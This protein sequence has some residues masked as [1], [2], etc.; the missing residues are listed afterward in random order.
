MNKRHVRLYTCLAISL[1][2]AVLVT[3][4][5]LTTLA[6]SRTNTIKM[7]N[8]SL[9]NNIDIAFWADIDEATAKK[10][11]TYMTFNDGYP[12]VYDCMATSG[13]VSYALYTYD[14][15]LP[16]NMADTVTAKLYVNGE[17]A[18]TREYSVKEYCQSILQ[19]GSSE[20]LKTFVSNLLVYGAKAQLYLGE[21]TD[22]L[23]TNGV[24]GLMASDEPTELTVLSPLERLDDLAEDEQATVTAVG[25]R[26]ANSVSIY[27]DV[28]LPSGA[29]ADDFDV[30]LNINGRQLSATLTKRENGQYRALFD[31]LM[32]SEFFDEVRVA[33]YKKDSR[34]SRHV[35]Y[36]V[37][38]YLKS[39]TDDK[40]FSDE[41]I[42]LAKAIYNYGL[43]AH[44]YTGDHV[45]SM[46]GKV[47]AAGRGSSSKDDHG[48]ITYTCALCDEVIDIIDV[49]HLRTFDAT[50]TNGSPANGSGSQ[51]LFDITT[52]KD[53]NNAYMS[54]LR[55]SHT[56]SGSL[57]YYFTIGQSSILSG[58]YMPSDTYTFSLDVRAPEGGVAATSVNLQNNRFSTDGRWGKLLDINA[59]GSLS[60]N[61]TSIAPAG[62][63]NADAWTSILMTLE[64]CE[65]YGEESIYVE[66]Y[67]NGTYATSCVISNA[68]GNG[69]FTN[70]HI[71]M[72]TAGLSANQGLLFDNFMFAQGCV[73]SFTSS[74]E[75]H[76][77]KQDLEQM[78][79]IIDLIEA[80]F[81][82]SDF[83]TV[84]TGY[85]N[86][87]GTVTTKT[88][89][90]F[91]SLS[92]TAYSDPLASPTEGQ[93]P[94]LLFNE[95]D[96]PGILNAMEQEENAAALS[97]FLTMVKRSTDGKLTPIENVAE[98]QYEHMNY[99]ANVLGAI[100]AKALYYALYKSSTDDA[101]SDARM[102]GYQAIYAMKNYLLT[103][104]IQWKASDQ[105]RIYGHVMYVTA[106]VYDWCYD[107]LSEADREQ[108]MLGVQNL[109]CDGTSN[110][111]SKSTHNGIKLE[112]GFPPQSHQQTPIT[113]HGAEFQILR[114]YAA[115]AIAIYD[116]NSTWWDN[117]G[118][119]LY[120]DYVPV[121]DYFY[122][123]GFYP[124][125]TACYNHYRFL[126]DLWN[127]WLFEGMGV[128]V[129]Y[130]TADM[131]TVIYGLMSMETY[132][133]NE[134][135]TADGNSVTIGVGVGDCALL[136][137][138]L[139]EDGVARA[140]AKEFKNDFASFGYS[141][142]SISAADFLLLSSKGVTTAADRF[143]NQK[144]VVYH[145]G[146]QQQIIARNKSA[147]NADTVVV[148]MQGAQRLP[149]GHTHQNAGNFQ[150]Y[151]KGQLTRD[152]GLY[153]AY[154]SDHHFYYHM[155]TTAHNGLLI[156]NP[157]LANTLKGYYNGGQ[158]FDLSIPYDYE[159]W[160]ADDRFSFG[161]CIG[162]QYDSEDAPTYVYFAND[163]TLAYDA[164]TVDYVERSFM[165][166]YTGDTETPMVMFIFDHIDADNANFQKTFLLQCVSAPTISGNT[167]TVDNGAGKLV[168]TSLLGGDTITAY[169]RT[170]DVN[171]DGENER[172]WLSGPSINLSTAGGISNSNTDNTAV[173]GHVE[174]QPNT[175]NRSDRLMNVLYVTDSGTTVSATPTLITGNYVTGAT[176]K[177]SSAV[178]VND[179]MYA[180]SEL[181]FS[182]TGSGTMTYYVGG[183]NEG[184]WSVA[185][186]GTSV[187]TYTVSEEGHMLTFEGAVGTV[188]L[189]P[190]EDIRPANSGVILYNLNGGTNP[191]DAPI[192]Y[193]Y[194]VETALPTP[195][196]RDA[197]FDG[198][199]AD[200]AY[201]KP[202]TSI[203]ANAGSTMNVYAK[204]CDAVLDVDYSVGGTLEDYK[205]L[206]H[207]TGNGGTYG[208]ATY[209]I[210]TV[211]GT[212]YLLWTSTGSTPQL[213]KAGA[214]QSYTNGDSA[215]S[216]AFALGKTA[217]ASVQETLLYIRN[218]DGTTKQDMYL[219][220]V[221]S[222][223]RVVLG[224]KGS[225]KVLGTLKADTM[226]TIRLVLDF[227][228]AT[229]S[230]FDEHGAC[231]AT[232]PLTDVYALPDGY[233]SY[234]QWFAS[235]TSTS[236]YLFALSARTAGQLRIES[237][238]IGV[239]NL[240]AACRHLPASGAHAWNDGDVVKEASTTNCA[241]GEMLYT[242]TACAATKS[243]PIASKAQHALTSAYDETAQTLVY[244]C[245]VCDVS[246][247]TD[248][249]YFL[250]GSSY[251]GMTGVDNS[252]YANCSGGRPPINEDGKYE[253]LSTS[254]ASAQ[255]QLWFP[256][257]N[258]SMTGF[259]AE[260]NAVGF[261]SFK[262]TSTFTEG[263]SLMFTDESANTGSNRWTDAGRIANVLKCSAP[264]GGN[265]MLT[266]LGVSLG[267]YSVTEETDVKIGI[268]LDE[269]SDTVT[270]YYF[271]NG[272]YKGKATTKMT[273]STNAFTSVYLSGT[274][275]TA[276]TG[277]ILDDIGF[278][279]T[280]HGT[281]PIN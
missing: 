36:S 191:S 15:V 82:I 175:G 245:T 205:Q 126:A 190:G 139:F 134:F 275:K 98:K 159:A 101:H 103:L 52:K 143:V 69:S 30:R 201:T 276:G 93:H 23:V 224:N 25:L 38:Q 179:P 41:L 273:I 56:A 17:L 6:A 44:V 72:G 95:S 211:D 263:F 213:F 97:N 168:L 152:D 280:K 240:F 57:G 59:N 228:Q 250:D 140:I 127:A 256:Q 243:V 183:L 178:F 227:A 88:Q 51:T 234:E 233:E 4:L 217:D 185:I 64:F 16:Q 193:T 281:L 174:I 8:L 35:L 236:G 122:S 66:Y 248:T 188:T 121:R 253:L 91:Q 33:V 262:F 5:T 80:G 125:G 130:N 81:D 63:V 65:I 167:V 184:T 49:S 265:V 172:F 257:N 58:T 55:G 107:L 1:I 40:T 106:L 84:V 279:F 277:I 203:P 164:V 259:S 258:A 147:A 115:F 210:E 212:S 222:D 145:D 180:A 249:T 195:T 156:Y 204:W 138:Y 199:F 105:C 24:E 27:F 117:I 238:R 247:R 22:T 197:M 13:G 196:K 209:T 198:W 272:T 3:V 77:K 186:N 173:W 271:V 261:F 162:M 223:G 99:D 241:P 189:T 42:A 192:Y 166:L 264:S 208:T 215:I 150:I 251:T 165:T 169:G 14:D 154:G 100:E 237:L 141:Q 136:S 266:G 86:S 96:I 270:F 214:Y 10:S 19:A 89:T 153:D 148:L 144:N 39:V 129:P 171:G 163:L 202:I 47:E 113:G 109:C 71:G 146:F 278:G 231:I 239:G 83:S 206:T 268:Q 226:T 48:T 75:E 123:S 62:T 76:L 78:Y 177:S 187:G 110:Y 87:T 128:D 132:D 269:A 45:V 158:K 54:V 230:A 254:D 246:F 142:S 260:N 61:G 46:P 32:T 170:S 157:N 43:S 118:G 9:D 235:F 137:S 50:H 92:T 28:S 244:S 2:C 207:G 135:G 194:G 267:S 90:Q 149:G 219:M 120:Q 181:T 79:E 220:Y 116:E 67:V 232:M 70:M 53:N 255:A 111:P 160:L 11:S 112:A 85:N 229:L 182:S 26:L 60:L 31:G 218:V 216:F 114:D 176:F 68:M 119:M 252:G 124:D 74:V 21:S 151:Y 102:R 108:L 37:A 73:H 131:A 94:R 200:V 29:K 155:S 242:C 20:T 133:G 161:E 221:E 225:T 104:D 34:V 12:V 18:D 274:T 7:A